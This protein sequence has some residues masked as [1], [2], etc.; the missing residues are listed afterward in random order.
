MMNV[1]GRPATLT[2]GRPILDLLVYFRI[3]CGHPQGPPPTPTGGPEMR[4]CREAAP[5]GF[6]VEGALAGR[7]FDAR[8]PE[9]GRSARQ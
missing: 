7:G 9:T 6:P 5:G 3:A 2:T 8:R 1:S 4:G